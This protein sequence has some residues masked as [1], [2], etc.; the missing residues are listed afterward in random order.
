[1]VSFFYFTIISELTISL[2]FDRNDR[3]WGI[4]WMCAYCGC[5]FKNIPIILQHIHGRRRVY[6][7][8]KP[9]CSVRV[10]RENISGDG[11]DKE[12]QMK[13][14]MI[15]VNTVPDTHHSNVYSSNVLLLLWRF[16]WDKQLFTIDQLEKDEQRKVLSRSLSFSEFCQL[17]KRVNFEQ[18]W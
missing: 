13:P 8:S 16:G 18:L 15:P 10:K 7:S 6:G 2:D 11:W 3:L 1:M 12:P 14:W 4:H 17:L 5:T 9:G